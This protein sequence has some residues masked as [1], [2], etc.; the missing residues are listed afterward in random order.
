MTVMPIIVG[1]LGAA[2]KVVGVGHQR[3]IQNHLDHSFFLKIS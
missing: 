2:N 1:V 3:K